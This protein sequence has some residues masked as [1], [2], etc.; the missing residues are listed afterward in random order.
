[1][2]NIEKK[3]A[4]SKII[5]TFVSFLALIV[6]VL[7]GTSIVNSKNNRG[8]DK[9]DEIYELLKNEWLFGEDYD[10]LEIYLTDLA[11]KGM[12]DGNKDPYTFYTS[13]YDAQNLTIDYRGIGISHAYYGGNRI[14]AT[15][16]KESPADKEGLKEGDIITGLYETLDDDTL[17]FIEFS[18]LSSQETV[19]AFNNYEDDIVKMHIKRGEQEMDVSVEKDYYTQHAI[20][21]VQ[22]IEGNETIVMVEIQNF[23][24]SRLIYDLEKILDEVI[25]N[26]GVI[27]RLILDLRNNG[28][29]RT[30]LAS[31]LASLFVPQDSIIVKYQT[32]NK[33]EVEYNYRKPRYENTV[34]K[35]NFLQNN[36]TASAS[37]MVILALKDNMPEKV[38]VIGT[39]SYGKG[40]RQKVLTLSDGSA[41]RYTDAY[42]LSPKGNS[43]HGTGIKPTIE[44][45]YDYNL[46]QYYGEIGFVT[47][48]YKEKIL[49]QING[50]LN[51]EYTSYEEALEHFLTDLPYS[52][53]NYEVGR[54]LQQMAYDM[55]LMAMGNATEIALE[56]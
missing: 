23:M 46:Q 48:E 39:Y 5:F 42:V 43:I 4:K 31:S 13:T 11:I 28:G 44:I 22:I 7:I 16:F 21:D 37:E 35:I 9:I 8:N 36:Q 12:S 50:V 40:I 24:D 25:E 34:K 33:L 52:Q 54:I 14:I 30:D 15:V 55:Y 2:E 6:G 41:I 45:E 29:G 47:K 26:N 32:K 51:M 19:D 49:R 38:D 20:Q 18:S 1:M 56:A 10:D 17:N 3:Y 27:D 53:F